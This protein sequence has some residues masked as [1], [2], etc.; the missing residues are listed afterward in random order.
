MPI[1]DRRIPTDFS[2]VEKHRLL[3]SH[4]EIAATPF[5]VEEIL[6]IPRQYAERYDQGV[7]GACVGFGESWAMS[8]LNRR[9]YDARWLYHEAQLV[10]EWED[11]PPAEGTS[12]RAGFDILRTSGHR[13]I[14]A[15]KTRPVEVQQGIHSNKWTTLVDEVRGSINAGIPAVLGVNWYR[16][17]S[18]PKVVPRLDENGKQKVF[19]GQAL[20]DHIIGPAGFGSWGQVDGGHCICLVGASDRRQAFALCNT[21]GKSYPFIVWLPYSSYERLMREDGETGIIIDR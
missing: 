14:Y 12:L 6:P 19:F 16:Q 3:S 11:T 2:H 10:D 18:S 4:P 13:R 21:W 7:E 15:N 5:E 17:F 1:L 8:I 20:W 9:L